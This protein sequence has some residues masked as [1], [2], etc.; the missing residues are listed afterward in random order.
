MSQWVFRGWLDE[1]EQFGIHSNHHALQC[2]GTVAS[3]E[4][5]HSS[6]NHSSLITH[7]I[8]QSLITHHSITHSSLTHHS[9]T[10]SLIT[11]SSLNHSLITHSSLNHSSLNHSLITHSSLT[12]HSITHHSSLSPF[13]SLCRS[14]L[15]GRWLCC[16][17]SVHSDLSLPA[18]PHPLGLWEGH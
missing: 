6:L 2:R 11:Q 7:S 8:T 9:I 18:P 4:Q 10:H 3:S 1:R 15:L 14:P 5:H 13:L 16:D 17:Q 12:H